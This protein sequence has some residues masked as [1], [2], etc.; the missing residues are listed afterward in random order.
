MKWYLAYDWIDHCTNGSAGEHGREHS[1]VG[2][3]PDGG[4]RA[5][6]GKATSGQQAYLLL[7]LNKN[8]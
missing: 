1:S 4:G 5:F 3:G 2:V 7:G 8:R 6:P